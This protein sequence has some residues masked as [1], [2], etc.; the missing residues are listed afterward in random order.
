MD[1]GVDLPI[2]FVRTSGSVCIVGIRTEVFIVI[3]VILR[4][5]WFTIYRGDSSTEVVSEHLV[6]MRTAPCSLQGRGWVRWVLS[7]IFYILSAIH[8]R[9]EAKRLLNSLEN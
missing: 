2:L 7:C 6:Y 4:V 1:R 3:Q 9:I 8:R 5:R